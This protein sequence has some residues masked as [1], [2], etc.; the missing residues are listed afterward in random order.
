MLD[1]IIDDKNQIEQ[2]SEEEQNRR[3]LFEKL[4]QLEEKEALIIAMKW[5]L[6]E[7]REFS[8]KEICGR[9]QITPA[10]FISLEVSGMTKLEK[11][12]KREEINLE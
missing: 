2:N 6:L 5:G 7:H 4:G 12:I 9:L 11:S 8:K 1:F 3:V 10:E